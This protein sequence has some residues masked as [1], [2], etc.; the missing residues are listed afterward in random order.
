MNHKQIVAIAADSPSRTKIVPFVYVDSELEQR[1]G[2]NLV[3]EL[4]YHNDPATTIIPE[5]PGVY[6][7]R[8]ICKKFIA[9]EL[10]V[11]FPKHINRM[12]AKAYIIATTDIAA[13]KR[14]LNKFS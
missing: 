9:D 8:Y 7:V 12:F 11:V 2:F 13:L 6:P 4:F 5:M 3:S 14:A 1:T 10:L